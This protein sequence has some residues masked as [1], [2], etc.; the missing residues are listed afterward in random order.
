MAIK[1][2][3]YTYTFTYTYT[4]SVRRGVLFKLNL[5]DIYYLLQVYHS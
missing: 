3:T 5:P 2:C 4:P 1:P